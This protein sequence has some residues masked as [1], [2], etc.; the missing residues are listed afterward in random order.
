MK[1][2]IVELSTLS[3]SFEDDLAAYAEAGVDAIGICEIK[4]EEGRETDQLAALRR[5]GLEA[6]C[7]VPAV[8]S[9]LPAPALGGPE[10]PDERVTA[11]VAGMRRLAPFEPTAFVCFTGPAGELSENEAR[12]TVIDGLRTVADEAAR[13]GIPAGVEPMSAHFRED[14]TL[15]TT[16]DEAAALIDEV[17]SDGLGLTFDTWHL[18]DTPAAVEQIGRH[19]PRIVCVHVAD[20]RRPTRGWC[21]RVLPGDGEADLPSLLQALERVGWEGYYELEIFSD[22]GAFGERHAGSLWD[23]PATELAAR[24]RDALCTAL[25]IAASGVVIAARREEERT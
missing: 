22:N 11:M 2:G 17:G 20:W 16:L 19:G 7:A 23:L 10:G 18:W 25:D 9:I 1:V 24:G 8:P 4:L 12:R 21:D 14:W 5:S 6:S 15:V 3:A 13:L